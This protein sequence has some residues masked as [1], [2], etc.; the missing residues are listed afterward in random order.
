M[1]I[2]KKTP[3]ILII[4]LLFISTNNLYAQKSNNKNSY[5]IDKIFSFAEGESPSESRAE[6][7]RKANKAAFEILLQ[8]LNIKNDII[9]NIS[10]E[11]IAETVYSRRITNE[12]MAGNYYSANFNIAFVENAITSI[13]EDKEAQKLI[14]NQENIFLLFPVEIINNKSFLWGKDNA[15]R[16]ALEDSIKFS[17]I[18]SIV[19]PQGDYSDI[20]NINLNN[21]K[22][23]IF[24]NFAEV[25]PKYNANTVII[26]YFDIDKI[27]N[28]ANIILDVIKSSESQRTRLSFIN[29]KNL[30]KEDL[31]IEV[32]HRTLN[33]ILNKNQEKILQL[34]TKAKDH[35][36]LSVTISSLENWLSVKAEIKKM[37]FIKDIELKSISKDFAKIDIKYNQEY[38]N[39]KELFSQYNFLLKQG[40]YG[41]SILS[42]Q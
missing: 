22:D 24:S 7:L 42:Y 37:Y 4:I 6:A 3:I 18:R 27:E 36:S 30:N 25:L 13:L 10:D 14:Q 26:A 8:N 31:L 2:Y 21:I 32:S 20:S 17:N 33:H 38:S 15:W 40:K 23:N 16:Q 41:E 9:A 34:N 28:K 19:I 5:L 12:R 35:I 29:A 39:S 11:E 1:H